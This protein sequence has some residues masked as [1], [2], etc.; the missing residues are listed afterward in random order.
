M[1]TPSFEWEINIHSTQNGE[2]KGH[3]NGVELGTFWIKNGFIYNIVKLE[4]LEGDNFW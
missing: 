1:S 2:Q 3:N 4:A